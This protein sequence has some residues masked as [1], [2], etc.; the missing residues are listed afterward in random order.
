[1]SR[2]GGGEVRFVNGDKGIGIWFSQAP[3]LDVHQSVFDADSISRGSYD[4]LD[5]ILTV[6]INVRS[7]NDDI[8]SF[9]SCKSERNFC[10][11][12][13]EKLTYREIEFVRT[14]R[15]IKNITHIEV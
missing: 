1:L 6:L 11:C 7:E 15:V 10:E 14:R 5:I 13:I 2:I 8:A 12:R 9:W 4:S 3:F